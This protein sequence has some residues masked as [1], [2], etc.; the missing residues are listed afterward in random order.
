MQQPPPR[1]NV[2]RVVVVSTLIF[3]LFLLGAWLLV[4]RDG[5]RLL[6]R[7]HGPEAPHAAWPVPAQGSRS[8]LR[9]V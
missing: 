7:V 5:R 6:P 2:M 8:L 4:D 9:Q 3:L 1:F